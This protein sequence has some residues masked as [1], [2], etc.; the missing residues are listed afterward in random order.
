M[1]H[2]HS[3]YHGFTDGQFAADEYFQ[4]W[5][6]SATVQTDEFWQSYLNLN[7]QA[8]ATIMNAR[9]LVEELA[10]NNY[11]MLPLSKEEKAALKLNIYQQ[12]GIII[13]P[14][15]TTTPFRKKRIYMWLA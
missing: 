10:E 15:E 3:Y 12:L 2:Y 5:V 6:L 14:A 1:L 4:Q 11:T 9:K 7:P 13:T 8:K